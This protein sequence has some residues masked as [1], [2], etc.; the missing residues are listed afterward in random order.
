MLLMGKVTISMAIFN[1]YVRNYQ[2]VLPNIRWGLVHNPNT[3]ESVLN[4]DYSWNDRGILNTAQ[5]AL[6]SGNVQLSEWFK[7]RMWQ[8]FGD[9]SNGQYSIPNLGFVNEQ[10][11]FGGND[12]W[13]V[14]QVNTFHSQWMIRSTFQRHQ[15][16]SE[17]MGSTTLIHT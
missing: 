11:W 14:N 10:P 16:K 12:S 15:A 17:R 8:S 1:S 3:W 13:R 7:F 6:F 5:M 2:R 4:Q 9:I